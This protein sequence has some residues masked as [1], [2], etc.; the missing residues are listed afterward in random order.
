[1]ISQTIRA[2]DFRGQRIRLS[3]HFKTEGLQGMATL[4]MRID[5]DQGL[6]GIDKSIEEAVRGTSEWRPAHI[7]LDVPEESKTIVGGDRELCNR[8]RR[9]C[10]PP[11]L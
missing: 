7:V 5:G 1:M 2:D 8:R 3:A 4:W 9:S 6:L 11:A 10:A